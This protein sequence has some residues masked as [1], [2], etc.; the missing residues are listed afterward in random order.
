MPYYYP[1]MRCALQVPIYGTRAQRDRLARS[2]E[3]ISFEVQPITAQ[4][5]LND[6][7]HAD[8]LTMTVDWRVGGVDPKLIDDAVVEF[9][10][11]D[12]KGLEDGWE[13][14]RRTCRFIGLMREISTS[15]GD[16]GQTV[17]ITAV[18]YTTL[19]LEANPFGSRGIPNYSMT[20][21]EAWAQIVSEVSGAE[22]L[23]NRIRFE[24]GPTGN[25]VLGAAVSQRFAKL[26]KVPAHP[27]TDAWAVWQQCVGMLGLVSFFRLDEC[28]V[29]T[30]TNLYTE[31]N[32]PIFVWGRN[33]L[34]W[35]ETRNGAQRRKGIMLSSFDPESG[36]AIEAVYP[37]NADKQVKRKKA[38]AVSVGNSAPAPVE[39]DDRE[40]LQYPAVTSQS[41]LDKIAQQIWEERSRQELEGKIETKEMSTLTESGYELDVLE[42]R[43]GDSIRI[44]IADDERS[45]LASFDNDSQR[46]AYLMSFGYERGVAVLIVE[47]M[48]DLH[49]LESKFYVTS[50]LFELSSQGDDVE[51]KAE[52]S[53]VNRIQLTGDTAQGAS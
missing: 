23:A 19:F 31:Q 39:D 7:N 38:P 30:A 52:F 43:A 34:Q 11:G 15:R 10:M 42:I 45:L 17:T 41:Q 18:D 5:E 50:A 12:A 40:V 53:Y 3:L 6:H 46:V 24:G 29:T 20:L 51:F 33:I 32:A 36:K 37:P 26:A 13:T 8:R 48:S 21:R 35:E 4:L 28:I 27:K 49:R 16:D 14:S 25:E 1:R 2:D 44:A 9:H 47:G 22:F